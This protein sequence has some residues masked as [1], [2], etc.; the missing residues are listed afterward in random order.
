MRTS[1]RGRARVRRAR[2]V[3]ELLTKGEKLALHL[4]SEGL[5]FAAGHARLH[6]D[7]AEAV[8]PLDTRDRLAGLEVRLVVD[9]DRHLVSRHAFE[10]RD[11]RA[12]TGDERFERAVFGLGREVAVPNELRSVVLAVWARRDDEAHADLFGAALRGSVLRRCCARVICAWLDHWVGS[13]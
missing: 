11:V 4:R 3:G 7:A 10:S 2:A 6:G 1:L 9:D 13:F 12:A 8:D 5:R